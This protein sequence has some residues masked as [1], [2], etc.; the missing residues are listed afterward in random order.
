RTLLSSLLFLSCRLLCNLRSVGSALL[1]DKA[2]LCSALLCCL[3]ILT[4][5]S[6]SASVTRLL[7]RFPSAPPN[8]PA[9]NPRQLSCSLG[10]S[11]SSVMLSS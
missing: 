3:T 11:T 8:P 10:H 6:S 9:L 2:L 4:T 5:R 7:L 1:K